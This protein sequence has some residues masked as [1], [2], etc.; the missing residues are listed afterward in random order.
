[1]SIDLGFTCHKT[2]A[3]I[4][5][6]KM[7]RD[8]RWGTVTILNAIRNLQYVTAMIF[9]HTL[10]SKNTVGAATFQEMRQ[11]FRFLVQKSDPVPS[12]RTSKCM[13]LREVGLKVKN[14]GRV[15]S[16]NG[17]N[18]HYP[19]IAALRENWHWHVHWNPPSFNYFNYHPPPSSG[20]GCTDPD[21][22]SNPPFIQLF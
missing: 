13:C 22:H 7:L 9:N 20:L 11:N 19:T 18:Y 3:E 6:K 1:M 4:V 12:S 2:P 8:E 5:S 16:F 17:F 15:P 21:V 10:W 14:G